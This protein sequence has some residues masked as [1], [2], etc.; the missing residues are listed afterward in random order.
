VAEDY[1]DLQAEIAIEQRHHFL[2]G[3]PFGQRGEAADIGEQHAH[4]AAF[5]RAV[6]PAVRDQ[7]LHHVRIDE[8]AE[9]LHR[10]FARAA[11]AQVFG[12]RTG[13]VAAPRQQQPHASSSGTSTGSRYRRPAAK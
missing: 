4:L 5:T 3:M 9:Q 10:L 6:E 11:F 1:L 8:A 12:Q 13:E 7:L 2:R